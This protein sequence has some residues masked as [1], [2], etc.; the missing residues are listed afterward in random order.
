[1]AIMVGTCI[2]IVG[3]AVVI[4]AQGNKSKVTSQVTSAQAMAVAE[5]GATQVTNF[6]NNNRGL[7]AYDSCVAL[8]TATG[9]CSDVSTN[10]A[11]DSWV[12]ASASNGNLAGIS[13][14]GTTPTTVSVVG[15][16]LSCTTGGGGSVGTPPASYQ[17]A[18]ATDI[19]NLG[20]KS[21]SSGSTSGWKDTPDGKAQ[22]RLVSYKVTRTSAGDPTTTTSGTLTIEGRVNQSGTGASATDGSNGGKARIELSI[23]VTKQQVSPVGGSGGRGIAALWARD[24]RSGNSGAGS[25]MVYGD[26][27]DSSRQLIT[28]Q[29]STLVSNT[30]T[31]TL[32]MPSSKAIP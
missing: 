27:L 21:T 28:S 12:T 19:S 31:G 32:Q 18:S 29:C 3:M 30:L 16:G 9:V 1:M 14:T 8:D 23:P 26:V 5:T 10:T 2:I 25:S 13:N 11:V 6:L 15:G 22:Y 20:K 17:S 7:I 24:F 4:Q